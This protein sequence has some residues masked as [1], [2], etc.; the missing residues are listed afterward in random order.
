MLARVTG[1]ERGRLRHVSL[2]LPWRLTPACPMRARGWPGKGGFGGPW[3]IRGP[4]AAHGVTSAGKRQVRAEMSTASRSVLKTVVAR[5]TVGSN[6]TPTAAGRRMCWS[7]GAPP[8]RGR[9]CRVVPVSPCVACGPS[10]TSGRPPGV[11]RQLGS[12][13]LPAAPFEVQPLHWFQGGSLRSPPG[14]ASGPAILCPAPL[15]PGRRPCRARS[16]QPPEAAAT[17]GS[18]PAPRPPSARGPNPRCLP[19]RCRCPALAARVRRGCG[20]GGRRP[21]RGPG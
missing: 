5:V 8:V 4:G 12:G 16:M 6:P 7:E 10:A 20:R 11:L 13:E 1:E 17:Y 18:T 3:A 14:P 21:C 9:P 15:R 2:S 19:V